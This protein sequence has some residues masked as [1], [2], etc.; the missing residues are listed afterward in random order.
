MSIRIPVFDD[1][2]SFPAQIFLHE[3]GRLSGFPGA[4][5]IIP[6]ILCFAYAHIADHEPLSAVVFCFKL[7]YFGRGVGF[8]EV[9]QIH[10]YDIVIHIFERIDKLE[11]CRKFFAVNQIQKVFGVCNRV[12]IFG[13]C[14]ILGAWILLNGG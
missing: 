13:V 6:I 3:S 5:P 11:F 8:F 1:I 14:V 12:Y 9:K 7:P 4:I 10:Y 2:I